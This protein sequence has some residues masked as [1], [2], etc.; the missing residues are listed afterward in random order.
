[1]V[2]FFIFIVVLLNLIIR[3]YYLRY[4]M[5]SLKKFSLSQQGEKV[6]LGIKDD[7]H[8]DF[9]GVEGNQEF[10]RAGELLE[11]YRYVICRKGD[12]GTGHE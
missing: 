6:A 2:V 7:V 9:F 3:Q 10:K 5:T 11:A 8:I 12:Q 1:M 4:D